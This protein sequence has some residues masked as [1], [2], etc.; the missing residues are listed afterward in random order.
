[1]QTKLSRSTTDEAWRSSDLNKR[2]KILNDGPVAVLKT[3]W[4]AHSLLSWQLSSSR[5][6]SFISV[7]CHCLFI[8]PPLPQ[9]DHFSSYFCSFWH[10]HHFYSNLDWLNLTALILTVVLMVFILLTKIIS[11]HICQQTNMSCNHNQAGMLLLTPEQIYDVFGDI[12]K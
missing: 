8:P 3:S 6:S 1:M 9:S 4:V 12:K 11:K 7:P 10:R 2:I 5:C